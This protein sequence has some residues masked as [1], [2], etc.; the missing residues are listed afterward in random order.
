MLQQVAYELGD[1]EDSKYTANRKRN[2]DEKLIQHALQIQCA[3]C[4]YKL[5]YRIDNTEVISE[6]HKHQRTAD[7]GDYHSCTCDDSH[8]EDLH[9][10]TG[11]CSQCNAAFAV[12]I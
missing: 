5:F 3:E 2:Q 8:E 1:K 12:T 6:N 9:D 11:T 7:T 10:H 4:L